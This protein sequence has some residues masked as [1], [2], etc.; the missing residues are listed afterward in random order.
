MSILHIGGMSK[1]KDRD[2]ERERDRD[3]ERG[4]EKVESPSGAKRLERLLATLDRER[5]REVTDKVLEGTRSIG[6]RHETISSSLEDA[7]SALAALKTIESGIDRVRRAVDI[8]FDTRREERSEIVALNALLEHVRHELAAGGARELDLQNRLVASESALG[9]S[10]AARTEAE[11][12]AAARQAELLRLSTASNAARGEVAELKT[13]LDQGSKQLALAQEDGTGLRVRVEDLEARRQEAEVKIAAISQARAMVEAE[14]GAL[15][16]R[17]ESQSNE[18]GRIG[19]AVAEL[20]G[21]LGAELSRSRSLEASLQAAQAEV[22]R[23]NQ[24]MEEQM[25]N[26]KVHLETA[27]MRLDTAQARAARLEDE[28]TELN[29]QLQEAIVRDRATDRDLVETRQRSER[30]E[31][32]VRSLESDLAAARQELL[33]TEGARA[34]AVERGE[35]LSDNLQ[36]RNADVARLEENNTA[37]QERISTLEAE[38]SGERTSSSE[39][40]RTLTDLIERERSEHSIAQGALEAAR[41]D[42]ARL[43]LQLLKVARRK[44]GA[45]ELSAGEPMIED[46]DPPLEVKFG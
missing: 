46:E 1:D 11:G 37:L 5:V 27:E 8:E 12:A 13:L 36:G 40:A 16:R 14:R 31:E 20:E 38:L 34:A 33:A 41:K 7:I 3:R 32:R 22:N 10:K 42:R 39:R 19:R 6:E 15:E 28:N 21:R 9:E 4:P 18:L 17:A 43:H 29:R 44:P 24:A 2:R 26:T 30:S 35:R 45:E 23:L 25:A